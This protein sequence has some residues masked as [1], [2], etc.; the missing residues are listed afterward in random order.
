MRR[1][2]CSLVKESSWN[3]PET[4]PALPHRVL[5]SPQ[6]ESHTKPGCRLLARRGAEA[7][8][9]DG[10]GGVSQRKEYG[11]VGC[12][13]PVA[14]KGFSPSCRVG[15]VFGGDRRFG[16]PGF[17]KVSQWRSSARLR[18]PRRP[19]RCP[20]LRVR[21]A[22]CV[23]ATLCLQSLSPPRAPIALGRRCRA[24]AGARICRYQC[25][26]C[27]G[28]FFHGPFGRI[29]FIEPRRRSSPLPRRQPDEP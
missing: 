12:V 23:Q 1:E 18:A 29:R 26:P 28:H 7:V 16:L 11:S 13:L 25:Q 19:S 24:N 21:A 5:L 2:P 27:V 9:A 14:S 4:V 6:P 20:P 17:C 22:S 8:M 10:S 15:I 3:Y